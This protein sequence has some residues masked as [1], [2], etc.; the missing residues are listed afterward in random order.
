MGGS[1]TRD[2]IVGQFAE[3]FLI[4]T[5]AT[6]KLIDKEWK[7]FESMIDHNKMGFIRS[8]FARKSMI[9]SKR[10]REVSMSGCR[11][12]TE[13]ELI[14]ENTVME[15]FQ[16]K[17]SMVHCRL[18]KERCRSIVVTCQS[19]RKYDELSDDAVTSTQIRY[20]VFSGQFN[21]IA[22]ACH[23]ATKRE[24]IMRKNYLFFQ[25]W[26]GGLVLPFI[27]AGCT[28]FHDSD[29]DAIK[30]R[31]PLV[32]QATDHTCG[33]ASIQSV[34]AYYGIDRREDILVDNMNVKEYAGISAIARYMNSQGFET[35][36]KPDMPLTELKTHL[37]QRRPVMV[38]LQAWSDPQKD[39]REYADSWEDGH[40]VVVI[41]YDSVNIYV[42]DPSTTGNYAFVPIDEF[43]LRWHDEDDNG[44]I[45]QLG[46]V[47]KT[48]HLPV[49]NEKNILKMD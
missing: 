42:M 47:F 12:T 14:A 15:K 41:G 44:K 36:I 18:Q 25:L 10:F 2:E 4:K 48:D 45:R 20:L 23:H 9:L 1:L 29:S 7:N 5:E 24:M 22:N 13:V 32:R 46:L 49:Y 34:L 19:N 33:V 6:P 17:R 21:S 16:Y 11:I 28:G 39:P 43:M 38:V 40:W 8:H 27:M 26:F 3:A 30:V 37:D 31:V 35:L